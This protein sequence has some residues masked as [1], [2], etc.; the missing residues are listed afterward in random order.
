MIHRPTVA[1][2]RFP[3]SI[4]WTPIPLITWILPFVGHMGI[5]DSRGVIHDFAGPY[6]IGV[7]DM[8]FGEP[9]RYLPLG[10]L[11]FPAP[12]F[13]RLL[14]RQ[15]QQALAT[16]AS[17]GNGA[18]GGGGPAG[19]VD[20][21]RDVEAAYQVDMGW[22]RGGA[23]GGG[24][25]SMSKS[26]APVAGARRAPLDFDSVHP[27][28]SHHPLASDE[29]T[30]LAHARDGPLPSTSS[31]GDMATHD[32]AHG[33]EDIAAGAALHAA[34]LA[35]GIQ[36]AEQR[37]R[38]FDRAIEGISEHFRRTQM[39]NFFC[40]NCHS[41]VATCLMAADVPRAAPGG[42]CGS[43]GDAA[44]CMCF[45]YRSG[46]AGGGGD[47][48]PSPTATSSGVCPAPGCSTTAAAVAAARKRSDSNH[49][50]TGNGGQQKRP[51]DEASSLSTDLALTIAGG[52]Y[53]CCG[54]AAY[55]PPSTWNMVWLGAYM[56][57]F[58]RWVSLRRMIVTLLPFTLIL[59]AVILMS[60]LIPHK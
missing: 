29:L 52:R 44:S 28:G 12:V 42:L 46:A 33:E 23:S 39:Y 8:A 30:D 11:L 47:G 40:N 7:D 26:A 16:L 57:L 48:G 45:V 3:C 59:V 21:M 14:P 10:D 50:G 2:S 27:Q 22:L 43:R 53:C 60:T 5:C 41:F 4:V 55:A 36:T 15:L 35:G 1:R 51:D 56:F 6:F 31:T 20:T 54:C 18:G 17:A 49:G 19:G 34:V 37:L 13:R 9:T 24:E 38:A 32:G 58:G 25:T